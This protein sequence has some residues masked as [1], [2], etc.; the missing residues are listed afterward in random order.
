MT[1]AAPSPHTARSC[2]K[3]TAS[4]SKTGAVSKRCTDDGTAPTRPRRTVCGGNG[5]TAAIRSIAAVSPASGWRA[6]GRPW[7]ASTRRCRCACRSRASRWTAPGAPMPM[8]APER[9]QQGLGEALVRAWDRN[10]GAALALQPVARRTRGAGSAALPRVARRARA[11]SS[12]SRGARC[13]CRNWPTPLNTVVSALAYPFVQ[14]LARSRPLRA[15]CEPIRRFDAGVHRAMGAAGPAL[16][17]GRPP[18]CRRT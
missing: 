12:R 1:S 16:R 10:N 2:Q 13:G 17:P 15:E 6:K 7:S 11:W 3:S 8:V 18:R 9:E 5:S 4:E 14:V